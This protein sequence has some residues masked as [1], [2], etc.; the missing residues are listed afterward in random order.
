MPDSGVPGKREPRYRT[1]VPKVSL[2]E[3]AKS[4]LT[5]RMIALFL[6]LV[7]VAG[8]CIRL[9]AWQLDR[10]SE[11]ANQQAAAAAAAEENVEPQP[12]ESVLKPGDTFIGAAENQRV[13]VRGEYDAAGE[14][15]VP[16]RVLDDVSG[17]GVVTPLRV[18]SG[19]LPVLRGWVEHPEDVEPPPAG[20]VEVVGILRPSEGAN[21][22]TLPPGQIPR[23]SSADLVNRW[24]G[25]IWTGY[26]LLEKSDPQQQSPEAGLKVLPLP[27]D[28]HAGLNL[29]NVAYALEW[30]IFGA[31]FT[32]LWIRAVRDHAR[33]RLEDAVKET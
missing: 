16:N 13:F 5:L 22:E 1:T 31:F 33:Q 10:A 15:L 28:E 11:R 12:I 32:M 30:W 27:I 24:G 4:A 7:F 14:V 9:G 2:Y 21:A 18:D 29:Q 6:A 25:P 23:I 26:V 8:V 20:E 3:F 17:F 19:V